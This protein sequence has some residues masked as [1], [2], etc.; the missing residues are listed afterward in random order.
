MMSSSSAFVVL[1]YH[2]LILQRCG[3][4]IPSPHT[5]GVQDIQ[6]WHSTPPIVH[7]HGRADERWSMHASDAHARPCHAHA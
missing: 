5:A 7:L 1:Q 4:A 2:L 6:L 3:S